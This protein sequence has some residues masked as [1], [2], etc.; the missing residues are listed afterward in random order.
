MP[1]FGAH[2]ALPEQRAAARFSAM[3]RRLLQLM[4]LTPF[5]IS[6]E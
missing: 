1:E 4:N 6:T 2:S 3:H 5:T